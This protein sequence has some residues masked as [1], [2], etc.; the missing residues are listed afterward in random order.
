MFNKF[1][2]VF[3]LL[4]SVL[5]VFGNKP[6]PGENGK[7]PAVSYDYFPDRQ[8]AF[9]FRNW[10]LVPEQ[11]LAEVLGTTIENVRDLAFS[12]GL[13]SQSQPEPEWLTSK[14]Y[15]TVVRANW[16]LLNYK[17]LI[18]LLGITPEELSWRLKED[19]FL[20]VKL[21]NIK[22]YCE[23]LNYSKPTP[24]MIAKATQLATWVK[25][26]EP[27]AF[28]KETPRFTFLKDFPSVVPNHLIKK[29]K[30]IRPT[31]DKKGFEIRMVS[32]YC[33]EFGDPLMDPTLSSF[34][35]G[36]FAQLSD[37]GVN[38]LWLHTV[39]NTLVQP[40][41]DFPGSA[42]ASKR[43]EGLN[44]LVKRAAKF[45]IGIYLYMNEPR[46]MDFAFFKS[47]P[48]RKIFEGVKEADYSA[49][50][51][52]SVQVRQWLSSSLKNVFKNTPGLAGI[53]TI[54]GSENLTSCIS[55]RNQHECVRCKE[56]SYSEI[57]IEL[58]SAMEKGVKAGNP[59]AN[60][61]VW[62]WGWDDQYAEEIIKGL[63]K[64]CWL[65]SVSE[66]SLPIV[67]D[68]INSIVGEYS[69]SSVGPGPR[70]LEHWKFAHQAGIKTLAKVQVNSSWEMAAIPAVPAMNLVA[71]HAENLSKESVNGVMLSWSLGGYPSANID[72]FQSY[73]SGRM[74]ESLKSLAIK[75]YGEKAA[76]FIQKAW[77]EFSDGFH[78][79][80]YHIETVY[81]G[82]HNMGP[83]NPFYLTP[84]NMKS[85]M[86]G[87]PY[88]DLKSWNTVFPNDIFANQY[89]KV[90]EGFS[91]GCRTLEEGIKSL[92]INDR[93]KLDL[94]LIRARAV[95]IHFASAANQTRFIVA[96][97]QFIKSSDCVEKK[98][99]LES[100]KMITLK[101]ISLVKTMIPLIKKDSYLAFESSNHYFYIPQDLIEKYIN[102]KSILVWLQMQ[103]LD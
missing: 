10:T 22:P 53:F 73:Q 31:E 49:M 100:M 24:E 77:T 82:P 5:Q 91:R 55:H 95:Q 50:C 75:Y 56:R 2:I 37:V 25:E 78:E 41:G 88:D 59:N 34:P 98:N 4:F 89:N 36:L 42:D 83:A 64:S 44:K 52:S 16:N 9:V 29:Q 43:I 80:P 66:W 92:D 19:D 35:E 76:P 67:R 70:A 84:S 101:E 13:P 68:G 26:I 12:M 85:T 90:S 8:Y 33:A 61:L 74:K 97:D 99:L 38:A 58:I 96:R 17:Q 1:L 3:V 14:G 93:E 86:V 69:I 47:V 57:M 103:K 27:L 20:F 40:E 48:E 72:L 62:D 60:V 63:P 39:L 11:K 102:L 71:Q 87:I 51:T 46:G 15:I 81:N 45:G 32:S 94:E 65:M 18:H 79:F 7:I 28:G 6:L 30:K 21:G 54:T 23:P